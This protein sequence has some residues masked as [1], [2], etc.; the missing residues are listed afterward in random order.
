MSHHNQANGA[1]KG[2]Y[3]FGLAAYSY[4]LP[5]ILLLNSCAVKPAEET[6]TVKPSRR[7]TVSAEA[8]KISRS[9]LPV[10]DPDIE[11]AGD[12]IAE[13]TL[14]LRQRNSAGSLHAISLAEAE[15]KRAL[16]NMAQNGTTHDKL[17]STLGELA[18]VRGAIQH[19]MLDEAIRRLDSIN[20]QLDSLD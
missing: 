7:S 18:T 14:R 2:R 16:D 15:L 9:P 11:K 13:A 20:K 4:L 5:L 6:V 10:P 19:G 12:L 17:L 1:R 8:P 3:R